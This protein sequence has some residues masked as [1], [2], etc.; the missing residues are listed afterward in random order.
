MESEEQG[1]EENTPILYKSYR[2]VHQGSCEEWGRGGFVCD[3]SY[4]G[5]SPILFRGERIAMA[6][7]YH[8]STFRSRFL[9]HGYFSTSPC[10]L[11]LFFFQ[12]RC[13]RAVGSGGK[14]AVCK[15]FG[16]V[17]KFFF[18]LYSFGWDGTML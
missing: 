13:I 18:F 5:D 16:N 12:D 7:E 3:N 17:R 8:K 4:D 6:Q 2:R 11:Q 10:I 14:W 9:V 1:D 15:A